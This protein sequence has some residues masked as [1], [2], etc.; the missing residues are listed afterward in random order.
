MFLF[1]CYS[2]VPQA[3]LN[4]MSAVY[5]SQYHPC[6]VQQNDG[7]EIVTECAKGSW[8]LPKN[9]LNLKV[10]STCMILLPKINWSTF[11]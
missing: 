11:P 2:F 5:V 9:P 10:F 4:K 3:T 8:G 6:C 7:T 1:S